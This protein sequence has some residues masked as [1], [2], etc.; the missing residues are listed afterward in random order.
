MWKPRMRT[1][2]RKKYCGRV[3]IL[4]EY[5]DVIEEIFADAI[6]AAEETYIEY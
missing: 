4:E 2:E 5:Q 3:V 6:K 1:L